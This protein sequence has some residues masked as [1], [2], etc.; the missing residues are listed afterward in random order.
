L[1]RCFFACP[2]KSPWNIFVRS[3]RRRHLRP[4]PA[5][6]R[7]REQGGSGQGRGVRPEG[8][9]A[10][11]SAS[12]RADT[13]IESRAGR[14][15]LPLTA[16]PLPASMRARWTKG[17]GYAP[18]FGF[19]FSPAKISTHSCLMLTTQAGIRRRSCPSSNPRIVL[20]ENPFTNFFR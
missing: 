12:L 2:E 11:L 19:S 9:E 16:P 13:G 1:S 20:I 17:R 4:S 5:V 18:L 8:R 10:C 6:S 14:R 7:G 15:P 3:P